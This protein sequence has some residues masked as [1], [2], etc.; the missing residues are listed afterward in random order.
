ME[1]QY[2]ALFVEVMHLANTKIVDA[3]CERGAEALNLLRKLSL[4]HSRSIPTELFRSCK[5]TACPAQH[6]GT[7]RFGEQT[8]V[9]A[10]ADAAVC[11]GAHGQL[12]ACCIARR[13]RRAF[14]ADERV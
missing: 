6:P 3:N 7:R 4:V 11:A 5:K 9:H 10:C 14:C 13:S 2:P 12:H 1:D 8:A